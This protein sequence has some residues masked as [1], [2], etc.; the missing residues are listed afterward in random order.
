VTIYVA[1]SNLIP[2]VQKER[3]VRFAFSVFLGVAL[4]YLAHSL[5]GA[6]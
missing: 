3:G 6:V 1:A 2:E 4:Y 5:M